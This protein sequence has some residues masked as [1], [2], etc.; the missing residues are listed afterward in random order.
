MVNVFGVNVDE[1]KA[2]PGNAAKSGC[3]LLSKVIAH[4]HRG[5]LWPSIAV[6]QIQTRLLPRQLV[7]ASAPCSSSYHA[8]AFWPTLPHLLQGALL[9]MA[10]ISQCDG[11]R[12][13]FTLGCGSQQLITGLAAIWTTLRPGV[14]L[15]EEKPFFTGAN[16][17]HLAQRLRPTR[18]VTVVRA[19]VLRQ[20]RVRTSRTC[21]CAHRCMWLTRAGKLSFHPLLSAV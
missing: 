4:L 21:K 6:Q 12:D 1:G 16:V 7:L 3:S 10:S 14:L 18:R 8:D 20:D 5:H 9:M 17:N 11:H 15:L 19:G 13:Q 2:S